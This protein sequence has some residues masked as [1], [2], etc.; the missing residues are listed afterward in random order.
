VY[1]LCN[2]G[3]W[4]TGLILRPAGAGGDTMTSA[5]DALTWSFHVTFSSRRAWVVVFFN[6]ICHQIRTPCEVFASDCL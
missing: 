1:K 6:P 2:V 5:T 4:D 3:A